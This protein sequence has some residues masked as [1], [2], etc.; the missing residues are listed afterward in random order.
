MI[1]LDREY[2]RRIARTTAETAMKMAGMRQE[3][4]EWRKETASTVGLS[5]ELAIR[6]LASGTSKVSSESEALFWASFLMEKGG[7]VFPDFWKENIGVLLSWAEGGTNPDGSVPTE[8]GL[9]KAAGE[10][11]GF[12]LLITEK[13]K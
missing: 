1:I 7:A 4:P 11:C 13:R 10:V 2:C 8:S 5:A 3:D 9:R 6:M 12:V